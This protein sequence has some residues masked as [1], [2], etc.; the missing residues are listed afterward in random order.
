MP[1]LEVITFVSQYLWL[2][3]SLL[4]SFVVLGGFIYPLIVKSIILRDKLSIE[5]SSS[6]KAKPSSVS[7]VKKMWNY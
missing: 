5:E 1:Q 4:F 3:I 6:C 2:T 7:L